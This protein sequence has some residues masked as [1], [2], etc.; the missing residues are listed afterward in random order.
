MKTLSMD[1]HRKIQQ[2][3]SIWARF[4]IWVGVYHMGQG[5]RQFPGKGRSIDWEKYERKGE[6]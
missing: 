2:E 4:W 5:I 3:M 6:E 1:I